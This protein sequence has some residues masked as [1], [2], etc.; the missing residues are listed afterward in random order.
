MSPVSTMSGRA[1]LK[2]EEEEPDQL[3]V[4]DQVTIFN[5]NLIVKYED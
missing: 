2:W 5:V 1:E 3:P 4:S